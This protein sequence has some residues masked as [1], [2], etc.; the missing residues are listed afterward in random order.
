MRV[1]NSR[2]GT[3]SLSTM[4]TSMKKARKRSPRSPQE[5][6]QKFWPSAK[7]GLRIPGN[8]LRKKRGVPDYP[9]PQ[10]VQELEWQEWQPEDAELEWNFPLLLCANTLIFLLTLDDSHDGQQ[11]FSSE[12]RTNSSKSCP[13]F[14]HLYSNIGIFSPPQNDYDKNAQ[15]CQPRLSWAI[16]LLN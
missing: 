9:F 2:A 5:K 8:L 14:L 16:N 11:T 15:P 12:F 3:N 6:L 10:V 4:C 13:H 7:P 1:R